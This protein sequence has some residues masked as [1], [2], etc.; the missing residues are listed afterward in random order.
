MGVIQGVFSV[1]TPGLTDI[2]Q[3]VSEPLEKLYEG[4][5]KPLRSPGNPTTA[6]ILVNIRSQGTTSTDTR[7]D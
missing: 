4:A 3:R 2:Q 5:E 1:L 7:G 6:V